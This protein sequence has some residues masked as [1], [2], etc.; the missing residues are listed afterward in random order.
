M[1]M[2]LESARPD[3]YLS[4]SI[5]WEAPTDTIKKIKKSGLIDD[6]KYRPS[7][8]KILEI[9]SKGLPNNAV[10]LAQDVAEGK[11]TIDD[12][13]NSSYSAEE[14]A[15]IYDLAIEAMRFIFLQQTV[16]TITKK[17]Q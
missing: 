17:I 3:L 7:H 14:K 10:T 11:K 9:Y 1:L 16:L 5:L 6:K 2:L 8:I 4:T 12:I 13:N 15:A